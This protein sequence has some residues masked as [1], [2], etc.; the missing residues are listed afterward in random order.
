MTEKRILV[1]TKDNRRFITFEKNLPS[2]IEF[3][4]TFNAEIELV[5]VSKG[6][7][8]LETKMLTAAICDPNYEM[9]PE[10][11]TIRKIFPKSKK[12]RKSIVADASGIKTFIQK[13][14]LSGK[15]LSLKDLKE[16]YKKQKLTDA[17]LCNHMTNVRKTMIKDGYKFRKVGAG[18]YRL[19]Q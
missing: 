12:I 7:K 3:A 11:K 2:L 15:E 5:R 9:K 17:C 18:K 1:K 4:K 14:F 8:T 6:T 10:Y 16:K 13:R 19:S